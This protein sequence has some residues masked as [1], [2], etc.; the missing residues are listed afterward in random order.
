MNVFVLL[1]YL[2]PQRSLTRLAGRLAQ[3][4]HSGFKNRFIRWFA[5]RYQVDMSQAEQPDLSQYACFN[6]FFTRALKPD[7]RPL[8]A[9]ERSICCPADG[10][11]SQMGD[12]WEDRIF[13]AK[14]QE[15]RLQQLLGSEEWAKHFYG[16]HFATIYLSPKDYHRVHMPMAGDLVASKYI[17]GK[18]FSVNQTTAEH[19]PALFARNE[20]LVCLFQG[21]Q[22]PFAVVLVGA[23]IVA[24]IST[25]WG[26]RE[27]P[28]NS[29]RECDH[30]GISLERGDELGRFM[31]GSTAI[32]LTPKNMLHFEAEL[33]AKQPVQ[34]NQVLGRFQR[35]L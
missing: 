9:D 15:Y 2:V 22:G 5:K 16:G 11:I 29:V 12:I 10:V 18:L 35:D 21:E 27:A 4:Q 20:R 7:A 32:L 8:P 30:Q 26:G 14:G 25:P 34:V 23:M 6:D 31:L 28:S 3:C 24:G 13:Q 17:P 33:S 19:V 1:Q